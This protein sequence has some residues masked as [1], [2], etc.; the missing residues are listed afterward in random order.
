MD[1]TI[2]KSSF[3]QEEDEKLIELH[4]RLG[5]RWAEIAKHLPGRTD[6]AIKNHWNSTLQR[7]LHSNRLIRAGKDKRT[8][9]SR[10]QQDSDDSSTLQ[11]NGPSYPDRMIGHFKLS[12]HCT[13][14][15]PTPVASVNS[16]PLPFHRKCPYSS[17][18][19]ILNHQVQHSQQQQQQQQ[20]HQQQNQQ[21]QHTSYIPIQN[22]PQFIQKAQFP[23]VQPFQMFLNDIQ[24]LRLPSY[25]N[26]FGSNQILQPVSSGV[27]TPIMFFA[28]KPLYMK[29]TDVSAQR[30]V[31]SIAT[32]PVTKRNEK[33][34]FAPLEMLSEL[35][36]N[37][38]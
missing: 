31:N 16:T 25:K 19:V 38:M 7:K 11:K 13:S 26:V 30:P 1:P 32:T 20:Q 3:S 22:N 34:A 14:S 37:Q 4:S 2:V 23:Q 9:T 10:Y 33:S 5:N 24:P 8:S 18:N 21:S 15:I 6:N 35:V 17:S 12:P 36:S 27:A 29:C 28:N